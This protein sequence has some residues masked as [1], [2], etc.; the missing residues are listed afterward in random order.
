M[1]DGA[2][3]F[4]MSMQVKIHNILFPGA[5]DDSLSHFSADFSADFQRCLAYLEFKNSMVVGFFVAHHHHRH[6]H[7]DLTLT[8]FRLQNPKRDSSQV[9]GIKPSSKD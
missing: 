4:S 1:K 7:H 2:T 8:V 6:Q 9:L 5:V 3:S